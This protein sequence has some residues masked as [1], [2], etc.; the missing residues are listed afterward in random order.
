MLNDEDE[1]MRQLRG[2]MD[3]Q[4]SHMGKIIDDLLDV[5]RITRGRIELRKEQLNLT[6]LVLDG[7][8]AQRGVFDAGGH[9]LKTDIPDSPIWI[10]GDPTRL[11]QVLDNLLSNARKFTNPGGEITIRL[12]KLDDGRSAVLEVSDTC[13]L[14]TSD[15][16]DE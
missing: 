10:D 9:T 2:V 12:A 15:A 1:T 16:A 8:A 14:Y 11:A 4:V 3:R 7:A 13:L 5:S 6:K